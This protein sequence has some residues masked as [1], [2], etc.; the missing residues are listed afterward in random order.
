L[1][2]RFAFITISVKKQLSSHVTNFPSML[3]NVVEWLQ[4]KHYT[5]KT[6]YTLYIA[7]AC[8]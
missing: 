1:K 6:E 8:P 4:R 7:R 2:Q 5:I 3:Q